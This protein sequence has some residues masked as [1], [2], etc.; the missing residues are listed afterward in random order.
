MGHVPRTIRRALAQFIEEV[1]ADSV[2]IVWTKTRRGIT[3]THEATFGNEY[4]CKGALESV[5]DDWTQP[6]AYEE[7]DEDGDSGS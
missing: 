2:V 1:G 7:D 3:S 4:A 5:L 6:E